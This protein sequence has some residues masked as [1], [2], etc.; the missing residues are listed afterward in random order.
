MNSLRCSNCAF[1]NFATAS[2]CKR[3]GLPFEASAE[4]DWNSQSYALQE[5]YP[6][7]YPQPTE[8]GSYFWD[9][10][11][12]RPNYAPP[13]V[14]VKSGA[15]TVI[16]VFVALAVV[17]LLAFLAI[18]MLLKSKQTDF[19]NLTTWNEFRSPDGKFSIQ[20]PV[21]P[22]ISERVIPTP[23]GNAQAH[24]LEAEV[25]KDGGCMM[26]YADYPIERTM[27]E[28]EIYGMAIQ[29]A[30]S[31]QRMMA[32]GAQKYIMLESGHRGMEAELKPTDSKLKVTGGVRMFWVSPRLYVIAAGGPNSADFKAVQARCFESFRLH[33]RR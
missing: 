13:P 30:T 5:S 24:V 21:A 29:G 10:P 27:S 16:K 18:P 20:L 8:G 7:P 31:R 33:Q 14:A 28:D 6:P 23:F 11:S 2:A 19:S 32:V 25:S 22:K 1:L 4:T 9:Q 26:L 17:A 12:Y 15:S 3:C